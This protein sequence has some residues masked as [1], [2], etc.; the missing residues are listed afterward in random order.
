MSN[1]SSSQ[2]LFCANHPSRKTTLRCN[3]C[4]KPVCKECVKLTPVGYRCKQCIAQHLFSFNPVRW[5]DYCIVGTVSAI[6]SA[7]AG[8]LI[9]TPICF[10]IFLTPFTGRLIADITF[11][12]IR[13]RRG[14]Y[15]PWIATGGVVL[16]GLASFTFPLFL[17]YID[18]VSLKD[19]IGLLVL[20][21]P[22]TYIIVCASSLNY[23]F[24]QIQREWERSVR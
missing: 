9:V 14:R 24:R 19:F 17:V 10:A 18:A 12:A 23:R 16:G 15:I 7:I 22:V 13:R 2:Q 1:Q 21:W 8:V 11:R 4:N 20:L 5:Y 3:K 6:L